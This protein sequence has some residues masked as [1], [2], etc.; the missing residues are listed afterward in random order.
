M[1]KIST[2]DRSA[3]IRLASQMPKGSEMRRAI[4][5][6]ISLVAADDKK[7]KVRRK[8]TGKV[9]EV[10]KENAKSPEYEAIKDDGGKGKS[11]GNGKSVSDVKV[12][13]DSLP[14]YGKEAWENIDDNTKKQVKEDIE[15]LLSEHKDDPQAL[16]NAL[17]KESEDWK[18][19]RNA[20][21]FVFAVKREYEKALGVEAK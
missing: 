5:A 7:V 20:S 6:G 3:L 17:E 2:Q 11:K 1:N 13:P 19:N 9:V 18:S 21:A 4:L 8:D 12:T 14:A 15:S 10:S 16:V